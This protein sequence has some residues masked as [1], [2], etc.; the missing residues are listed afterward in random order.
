MP[1]FHDPTVCT[2]GRC[3]AVSA[4][5]GFGALQL[6]FAVVSILILLLAS[7]IRLEKG[8]FETS[9]GFIGLVQ[10][11]VILALPSAILGIS[12]IAA[13]PAVCKRRQ[14]GLGLGL[15]G[16]VV[17]LLWFFLAFPVCFLM[18]ASSYGLNVTAFPLHFYL[19]I[20][21]LCVGTVLA[22]SVM[23]RLVRLQHSSNA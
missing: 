9:H 17:S 7:W 21:Y 5:H 15:A 13:A 3:R 11:T 22:M 20:L 12:A 6:L 1:R 19:F 4:L 8:T 2:P 16:T 18:F 14:W 23:I 10:L